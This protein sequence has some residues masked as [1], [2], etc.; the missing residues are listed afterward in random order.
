MLACIRLTEKG[1]LRWYARCCNTPVGNTLADLK[2]SFVGLVHSCLDNAGE[3][4][5]ESFGPVRMRVNTKSAKG[6]VHSSSLAATAGFMRVLG[7]LL[8][9]RLNGSYKRTAFFSP[10]TGAPVATPK[11]LSRA[12]REKL[13]QAVSL[14]L[15]PPQ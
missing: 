7:M 1:L 8:H 9:A 14:P 4:L 12:E 6:E 10:V 13:M 15:T 3:S 2:M 11:V 5:D